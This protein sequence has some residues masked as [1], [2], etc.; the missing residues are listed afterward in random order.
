MSEQSLSRVLDS[1]GLEERH[2]RPLAVLVENSLKLNEKFREET[3][4]SILVF[5][6]ATMSLPRCI[7]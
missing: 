6:V 4:L 1:D 7:G 3:E 5:S 2:K